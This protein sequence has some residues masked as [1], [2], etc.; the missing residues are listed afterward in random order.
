MI[1]G[2]YSLTKSHFKGDSTSEILSSSVNTS[3]QV[4]DLSSHLGHI[5]IVSN[6]TEKPQ[7]IACYISVWLSKSHTSQTTAE[8]VGAE[9][10]MSRPPLLRVLMVQSSQVKRTYSLQI[11]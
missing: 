6:L 10:Q 4:I 1:K 3:H 5:V 9:L 8:F 11:L 2:K 7:N